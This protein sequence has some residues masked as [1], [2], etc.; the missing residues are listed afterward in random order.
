MNYQLITNYD[1]LQTFIDLL[2]D[3]NSN[4]KYLIHLMARK[5]YNTKS[6]QR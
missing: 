5:K 1:V 2:P 4:E 6:Y 3:A